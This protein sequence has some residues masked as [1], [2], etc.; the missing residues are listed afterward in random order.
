MA[1][2]RYIRGTLDQQRGPILDLTCVSA[3]R[4]EK[5]VR[6]KCFEKDRVRTTLTLTPDDAR[7]LA[8]QLLD[9][10]EEDST[11]R[12]IFLDKSRIIRGS[13]GAQ[14]LNENL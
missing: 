9:A 3:I 11:K 4:R 7:R 8:R 10:A 14:Y 2:A 6:I 12:W 5:Q 1:K 13:V